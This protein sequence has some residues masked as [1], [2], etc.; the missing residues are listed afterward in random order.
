MLKMTRRPTQEQWDKAKALFEAGKSLRDIEGQTGINYRTVARR[1]AD[2]G[3]IKGRLSQLIDDSVRIKSEIVTF[4]DVTREVVTKEVDERT[5][6]I[7]F[8]NNA[9]LKNLSVMMKKINDDTDIVEH[10][11]AQ[12]AISKGRDTV[13]GKQPDTVVNNTNAQQTLIGFRVVAE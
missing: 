10:R 13:I 3:W 5:K 6:H 1:A 4:N 8:F 2:D 9:T 7:Q 12:E 11:V